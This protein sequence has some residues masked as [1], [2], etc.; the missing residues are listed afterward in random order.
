[1]GVKGGT[2]KVKLE[3]KAKNVSMWQGNERFYD[4]L[5]DDLSFKFSSHEVLYQFSYGS[6]AFVEELP[7]LQQPRN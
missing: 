3:A 4:S 7:P 6:V 5:M 1:M 2:M